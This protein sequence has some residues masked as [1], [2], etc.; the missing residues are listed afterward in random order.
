MASRDLA[1][2]TMRM[3]NSQGMG[4]ELVDTAILSKM[5]APM[6]TA[7][8]ASKKQRETKVNSKSSYQ[9]PDLFWSGDPHAREFGVV[10]ISGNW[11]TQTNLVI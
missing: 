2:Y 1:V 9:T 5:A 6:H 10:E 3:R 4:P 7:R 11:K 8:L